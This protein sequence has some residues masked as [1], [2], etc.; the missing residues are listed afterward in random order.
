MSGKVD[1]KLSELVKKFFSPEATHFDKQEAI[2]GFMA[3]L[4]FPIDKAACEL[5]FSLYDAQYKSAYILENGYD[6]AIKNGLDIETFCENVF[7]STLIPAAR[8]DLGLYDVD[9]FHLNSILATNTVAFLLA[10][11]LSGGKRPSIK[12][13]HYYFKKLIHP[14]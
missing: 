6:E 11:D 13:A 9:E 1:A 3:H 7:S 4:R 12:K 10:Y 14:R 5:V 2:I 8:D